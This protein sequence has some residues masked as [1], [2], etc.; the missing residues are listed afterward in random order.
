MAINVSKA[1]AGGGQRKKK[2]LHIVKK[3]KMKKKRSCK[4]E[5]NK[6]RLCF[7]DVPTRSSA[8]YQAGGR[9]FQVFQ[10]VESVSVMA[11]HQW[12][13]LSEHQ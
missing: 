2:V 5:E 7:A 8:V 11:R 3:K 1:H 12:R 13:R 4:K 10:K 6:K 9:A